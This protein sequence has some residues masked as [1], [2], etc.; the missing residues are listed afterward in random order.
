V[1]FVSQLTNLRPNQYTQP[2]GV[3]LSLTY[4]Q[5]A[6]AAIAAASRNTAVSFSLNSML[7]PA[8]HTALKSLRDGIKADAKSLFDDEGR[9]EGDGEH[10]ETPEEKAERA[11][12]TCELYN[13]CG[14]L[15]H[16]CEDFVTG[17]TQQDILDHEEDDSHAHR[18]HTE[19]SVEGK[20]SREGPTGTSPSHNMLWAVSSA[21]TH[22]GRM[23]MWP[24]YRIGHTFTLRH[25]P[26]THN[27][28]D[29]DSHVVEMTTM[30]T[31]PKVFTI[32][33]FITPSEQTYFLQKYNNSEVP[34]L[35]RSTTGARENMS[36][37][38][39]RTSQSAFDTNSDIAVSMK[40]RGF[41]LT[42]IHQFEEKA[43][44]G[45]Q[46][47][48]YNATNCYVPHHDWMDPQS[49]PQIPKGYEY[50]PHAP[51]DAPTAGRS[52]EYFH[53]FDSGSYGTNRFATIFLYL[54][55][56]A[57]EN[58]GETVFPMAN[59]DGLAD[60]ATSS[61]QRKAEA[62]TYQYL[63][64]KGLQDSYPPGS[65][66]L[67]MVSECR[68]RMSIKPKARRTVLFYSQLADGSLDKMSF[69]GGCPVL[70]GQKWAANLW[71][72]NGVR[73]GYPHVAKNRK[74]KSATAVSATGTAK[75]K[76]AEPNDELT[77]DGTVQLYMSLDPAADTSQYAY[78]LYWT[79]KYWGELTSAK[80]YSFNSFEKHEWIIKKVRRTASAVI[81]AES[82]GE[83]VHI[84]TVNQRKNQ[85]FVY[86]PK[87]GV[88][89]GASSS[90]SST[91]SR[92]SSSGSSS[93]SDE[94]VDSNELASRS[95]V[96]I[97][98]AALDDSSDSG[99][100]SGSGSA[101]DRPRGKR[102]L[103]E[104]QEQRRQAILAATGRR[105]SKLTQ[106]KKAPPPPP[107]KQAQQQRKTEVNSAAGASGGDSA[108]PRSSAPP[109]P[110]G[111]RKQNRDGSAR[112]P[113]APDRQPRNR[114]ILPGSKLYTKQAKDAWDRVEL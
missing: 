26:L 41:L 108:G 15:V 44:D 98:D 8:G 52:S 59:K 27:A 94:A 38:E 30:A 49:M 97:V 5:C 68:T 36:T 84:Y 17:Y 12:F 35:E 64:T 83:V 63:Q 3:P 46:I 43:S 100:G 16:T 78:V 88:T 93:A 11:A 20:L 2:T 71:I 1:C 40:K 82:E 86:T 61:E 29:G 87:T 77:S 51:H 58:G 89:R 21:S 4:R 101:T 18:Q 57:E 114:A 10:T 104:E 109:P 111:G 95:S 106:H 23:F 39:R 81:G 6:D 72:W 60:V 76:H 28:A 33:N 107:L 7:C 113:K 50:D 31:S 25:I 73:A 9:D 67:K 53:D 14:Q 90:T 105:A 13:N 85:K 55:D 65:W 24:P 74:N 34:L 19:C 66:Q 69:H 45:I 110:R 103:T 96:D 102:A 22:N 47:L 99:S 92:S 79:D 56:V 80:P 32:E 70:E 54:S 37:F 42:G 112:D 75:T 91:S 62:D 48:R